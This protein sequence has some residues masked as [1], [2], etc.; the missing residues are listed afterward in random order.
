MN[1]GDQKSEITWSFH[2]PLSVYINELSAC[3]F[4]LRNIQEVSSPKES[5]GKF[6]KR[7]NTARSEIPLFMLITFVKNLP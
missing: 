1:P 4:S 5:Q 2:V 6:A 3:G 7:E